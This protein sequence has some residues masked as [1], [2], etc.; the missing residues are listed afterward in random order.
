[1]DEITQLIKAVDGSKL[2]RCFQCVCMQYDGK[3][4]YD[5]KLTSLWG[6]PAAEKIGIFWPRAMLRKQNTILHVMLPPCLEHFPASY[7]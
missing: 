6:R 5:A 4:N 2:K 1:M 3:N 7:D